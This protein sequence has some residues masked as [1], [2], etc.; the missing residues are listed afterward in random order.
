M[1]SWSGHVSWLNTLNMTEEKE[2]YLDRPATYLNDLGKRI[3]KE[4]L[5]QPGHTFTKETT[6]WQF[7]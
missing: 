3:E 7:Y 5:K 2:D 1:F 4:G 6:E